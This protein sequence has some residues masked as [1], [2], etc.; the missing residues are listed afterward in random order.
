MTHLSQRIILYSVE[1]YLD[2]ISSSTT[3][4]YAFVLR[5]RTAIRSY[6]TFHRFNPDEYRLVMKLADTDAMQKM[7]SMEVDRVI[8][9]IELLYLY[10][11]LIPKKDRAHLNISDEKIKKLKSQMIIDMLKLK[12]KDAESHKRVKE[13]IDSTRVAAKH[14]YYFIERYIDEETSDTK[15]E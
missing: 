11:T 1:G 15:T 8:F 9:A 13:I 7:S 4:N 12:G 5:I 2:D 10:T 3:Y 6:I 14:Y